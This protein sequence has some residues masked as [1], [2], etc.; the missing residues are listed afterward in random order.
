MKITEGIKKSRTVLTIL[1]ALAGIGVMVFYDYCGSGCSYLK[2]DVWGIDLK[3]VGIAYMAVIIVYAALRQTPLVRMLLAAGLGVE[4]FLYSFQVHNDVY[5][6]FCLLFSLMLI[7]A[8][9]VNYNVPSAWRENRR[10]KW[11]YLLGEV[12][13]PM[14]NIHKLP[15]LFFVVL[16][17][18]F[19]LFAFNGS[20]TPAYGA[21][22]TADIPSLGDGP[23]EV[24]LFTDIFCPPCR[25]IDAKAEPLFKELLATGRV[26]ITF[27]DVPFSDESV[28]YSKYYLYAAKASPDAE[29]IFHVRRILFEAAQDYQIMGEDAL[30]GHLREKGISL[31]AMDEKPVFL[32]MNTII[33][34]HNVSTTPSCV[35]KYPGADAKKYKNT[36][37]IWDGLNQLKSHLGM[38]K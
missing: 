19:I 11:L 36:N 38:D 4:A 30:V 2:G 15:L 32:M 27:V 12:N 26:T 18:L 28:F 14:L 3:W 16:G 33:R 29:N 1:L 20:V 25:T 17:Y 5:C 23:Y 21:E 35:I 10:G 8:F 34:E 37:K 7:A 24:T 6:P 22:R 9:I 13:V 31:E